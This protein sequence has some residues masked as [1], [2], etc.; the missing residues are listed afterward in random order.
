MKD[1][2]DLK[3][4]TVHDVPRIGCR[5]RRGHCQWFESESGPLRAV[6]LSRHKWPGTFTLIIFHGPGEGICCP[7]KTIFVQSMAQSKARRNRALIDAAG[8]RAAH[9]RKT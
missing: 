4:L 1:L 6:H 8:K 5:A 7:F 3:D 2:R 9:H